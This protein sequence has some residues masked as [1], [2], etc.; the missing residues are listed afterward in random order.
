MPHG[1]L[2]PATVWVN[3][4]GRVKVADLGLART[5][6]ALARRGV[7][8]GAPEH[9]YLAPE[10]MAG[11]PPTLASDVYALGVILFEVLTGRL[12]A[13]PYRVAGAGSDAPAAID[14]VIAKALARDPGAR[15]HSPM[16]LRQALANLQSG[17]ASDEP[18]HAHASP[19]AA[20]RAAEHRAA[21]A[22][23]AQASSP[24]AEQQAQAQ[25]QAWAQ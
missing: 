23:A 18:A 15:F 25:Q 12:P 5:L 3:K 7:P 10:L 8:T 2:N 9:A 14:G 4:A 11:G 13:P 6:P 19:A 21:S 24:Q 17:G 20:P 22:F 1:G 16:D